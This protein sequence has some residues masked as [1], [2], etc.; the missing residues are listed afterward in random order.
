MTYVDTS[1][2]EWDQP[3]EIVLLCAF[4]FFNVQLMLLSGIGKP[5]DPQTGDGV[6]GKNYAYQTTSGVERIFEGQDPQ[7]LHRAPARTA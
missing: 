1:G 7:S 5:Y 3:A 2:E 4:S 6:V